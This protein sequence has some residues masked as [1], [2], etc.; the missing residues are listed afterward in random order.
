MVSTNGI[1][2][3]LRANAC[4]TQTYSLIRVSVCAWNN[5]V[6]G[7]GIGFGVI[8]E[9]LWEANAYVLI[10]CSSSFSPMSCIDTNGRAYFGG[11]SHHLVIEMTNTKNGIIK[12]HATL[13]SW[14]D[15]QPTE[16]K[17]CAKHVEPWHREH[18][19]YDD[20]NGAW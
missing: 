15:W 1:A 17:G 20:I 3:M 10:V 2:G 5:H 13:L 6:D 19:E 18:T 14:M 9:N 12:M 7:G 4:I 16:L 8:S 11:F